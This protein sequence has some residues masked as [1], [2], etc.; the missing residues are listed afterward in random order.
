MK[1]ARQRASLGYP[2]APEVVAV[3]QYGL[4]DRECV[5]GV[6]LARTAA[7]ALTTGAPGRDF[8]HLEPGARQRSDEAAAIVAWALN[9]DHR[10]SGVVSDQ[11]VDQLA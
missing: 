1:G 3:G 10:I 6:G 9:R 4:R 5:A 11:P 7:V 8:E 2:S